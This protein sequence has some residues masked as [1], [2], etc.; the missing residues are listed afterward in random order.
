M[1][2]R[3]QR[4]GACRKNVQT[5]SSGADLARGGDNESKISESVLRAIQSII[6]YPLDKSE[7]VHLES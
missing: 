1:E 7:P 2:K 5:V 6:P 3:R 4:T